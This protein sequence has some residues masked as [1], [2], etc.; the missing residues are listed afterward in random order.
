MAE[1][2]S[3][4]GRQPEQLPGFRTPTSRFS[5]QDAVGRTSF[6]S[7]PGT[8]ATETPRHPAPFRPRSYDQAKGCGD[9]RSRVD[10]VSQPRTVAALG[11]QAAES[12]LLPARYAVKARPSLVLEASPSTWR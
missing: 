7:W 4:R 5:A 10:D 3:P 6:D 8:A 12:Y 9:L 11:E 2:T 1:L